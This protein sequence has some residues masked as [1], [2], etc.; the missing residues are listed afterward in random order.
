MLCFDRSVSETRRRAVKQSRGDRGHDEDAEA[1]EDAD[2]LLS[3]LNSG[4]LRLATMRAN[5]E[6]VGN[7]GFAEMT[8]RH[9][10]ASSMLRVLSRQATI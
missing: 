2:N 10:N 6:A 4:Q 9:R 1:D 3:L 7:L 5:A 8:G